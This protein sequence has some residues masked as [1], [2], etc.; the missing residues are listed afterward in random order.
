M[1]FL[2]GYQNAAYGAR[3]RARV[4]AIRNVELDRM[5]SSSA[6]ANAVAQGLFKLMAFKDEY[7]VARLFS[8]GTF[9]S[10]L[11]KLFTGDMKL[12]FHLAP[13]IFTRKDPLTGR[14]AKRRFGPWAMVLFALLARAKVL[15]GTLLDPFRY[16]GD[17]KLERRLIADYEAMLDEV[18]KR[19]NRDTHG[20]AV[21]LAVLPQAIRGFGHF[22]QAGADAAD[23]RRADLLGALRAPAPKQRH[24]A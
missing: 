4:E 24:A 3:Y 7:E 6:L 21:E 9:Q 5:P 8:D 12:E 15:R 11:D 2:T 18:A 22:K 14:P 20:V 13:P 17:R 1:R 23:A 10:Q 19:L 16:G